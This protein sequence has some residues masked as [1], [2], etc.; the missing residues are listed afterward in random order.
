MESN[1]RAVV[2]L[3]KH[4][5]NI[6]VGKK[7]KVEGAFLS[8]K[9]HVLGETVEKDEDDH[10][11]LIRGVLEEAG[12]KIKVG[13]FIDS[14]K[15]PKNTLVNWYECFPEEIKIKPGSDLEDA[16]WV[17]KSEVPKL[18]HERAIW[19][20]PEKVKEYFSN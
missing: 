20:W 4:G 13:R 12:I 6:L 16:K 11:A 7:K 2:A 9:W 3:V 15:T 18:C 14:H 19:L 17:H 1:K 10:A 8:E 5:D